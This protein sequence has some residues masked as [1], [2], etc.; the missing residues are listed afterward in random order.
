MLLQVRS[1]YENE[2]LS[3]AVIDLCGEMGQDGLGQEN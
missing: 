2:E 1:I 3:G